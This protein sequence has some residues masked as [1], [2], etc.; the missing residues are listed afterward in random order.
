MRV[1]DSGFI[2]T[3]DGVRLYCEAHGHGDDHLIVPGA[4]LVEDNLPVGANLAPGRQ[5]APGR[6]RKMW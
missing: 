2:R 1:V 3:A 6:I 5:A 4:V